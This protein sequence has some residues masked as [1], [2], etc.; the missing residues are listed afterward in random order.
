MS[1]RGGGAGGSPSASRA[2][3]GGRRPSG[4]G[5]RPRHEPAQ[6]ALPDRLHR[7][8]RVLLLPRRRRRRARHR[9]SLHDPGRHAGARRR[10]ADRPRHGVGGPAGRAPRR[11]R[12]GFE[13]HEVT[14][15]GYAGLEK[16]LA[17]EASGR[18][19]SWSASSGRSRTCGPSRTRARSS[20]CGARARWPTRRWPS[21]PP[22]ERCGQGAPSCRSAA[23][24]TPACS[25][26]AP[27]SGV[28][29]DDRR[30]RRQLGDPAPPPRRHRAAA[31]DFLKLDFGATVDGYHPT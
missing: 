15:D 6:R 23:S 20:R 10:A 7:V 12:L 29:R 13:S 30:D 28:V 5:R 1:R 8:Q 26:S 31:G 11:R 24:S 25:R 9:R 27:T 19:R 21:S 3:A 18:R 16:V 14:V 17:D 22:K 2:A 4:P